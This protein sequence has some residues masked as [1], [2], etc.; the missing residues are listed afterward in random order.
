MKQVKKIV[1]ISM[2]IVIA[3][4][5]TALALGGKSGDKNAT[6][7]ITQVKVPNQ[8]H[9]GAT[10][11]GITRKGKLWLAYTTYWKDGLEIDHK[12]LRVGKGKFIKTISY[13]MRKEGLEKVIVSLW[14]YKVSAKRCKKDNGKACNYCK[15]NGFHMEGRVDTETG[16]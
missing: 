7:E 1:V 15:K 3:T 11:T 9:P 4:S 2:L 14:R 5:L 8:F 6:G 13:P 12:P 10:V 16:S